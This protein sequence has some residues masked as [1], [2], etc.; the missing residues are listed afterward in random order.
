MY[1]LFISL[2]ITMN[3]YL[4]VFQSGLNQINSV[5]ECH[6]NLF[7]EIEK[8][9]TLHLVPYTEADS[10]PANAYTMAFIA[11]GGVERTVTQHFELLPYPIHLLTDG[12]QNSL[13]AS[14]EIATWLRNKGMKVHI[15]HGTLPDIAKQLLDHHRAF[16]AQRELK[17][18]RI[19]VVGQPAPWLVASNVDYLL[20]KRRWQIEFIDIPLEEIYCLYYQVT[21]DEIGYEA[22]VFANRAAACREGT[23]ED[24]LKAMRLYRAMKL[25]CQK[26]QL[27]AVT[28]SCFSLISKLGTTGCLALSLLNDEGIPAGCE[29]DLQSI[30]TML[31]AKTL[32]G[33]TGFMTN[34]SFIDEERNEILLAHCTIG[35]R[36]TERFNIRNHFET[37]SGI[38]IQ[39]I[40][41]KGEVTLV[42]C[43]GECLDEYFVTTGQL[44]ENT[45]YENTCRTQVKVRPDKPVDYFL[46][47]SLGNHHILLTGN[48]EKVFHEFLQQNSCR[49]V[50]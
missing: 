25:I 50:E 47:N 37:N 45:D 16:A 24:L 4:I 34:P 43:A 26:K 1:Y 30:F 18:K 31:V 49:Q 13:A 27:D 22:S 9:F 5:Y 38:A 36:M 23:P 28:L 21:D 11:S 33:Q 42:K 48:H 39:G 14:L 7:S 35:T 46:R 32:T 19:G 41:P 3:L 20:A 44:T 2:F 8:H 12:L 6:K 15:V 29:G 17:G 10:I 40:L